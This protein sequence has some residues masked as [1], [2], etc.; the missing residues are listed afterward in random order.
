MGRSLARP[1]ILA[2][3]LAGP[4]AGAIVGVMIGVPTL[5]ATPYSEW[6]ALP[7]AVG[8]GFA[9]GGLRD[10]FEYASTTMET[11]GATSRWQGSSSM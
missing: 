5:F 10:V 4:Y 9:G 11:I 3:L 8:C 2:G 7:F 1:A 6:A